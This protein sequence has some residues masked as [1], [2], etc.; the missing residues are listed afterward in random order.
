MENT[1]KPL[2]AK[3]NNEINKTDIIYNTPD[4][5]SSKINEKIDHNSVNRN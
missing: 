3:H 1:N 5:N 2:S 4:N